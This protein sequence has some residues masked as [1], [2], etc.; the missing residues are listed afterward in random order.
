MPY[1]LTIYMTSTINK[2]Y[3]FS[4]KISQSNGEIGSGFLY[5]P[6]APENYVYVL[7]AKHCI[8]GK[9]IEKVS[10]IPSLTLSYFGKNKLRHIKYEKRTDKVLSTSDK[11]DCA[12]ILIPK[13]R[14]P[15][16]S[17]KKP[18]KTT[19]IKL[20]ELDSGAQCYFRGFPRA[21]QGEGAESELFDDCTLNDLPFKDKQSFKIHI[22]NY[23]SN[24]DHASELLEGC[25]GSGV[26]VQKS[27]QLYL[28]G[29]VQRYLKK[30]PK[31]V[32]RGVNEFNAL[33]KA[34]GFSLIPIYGE[35]IVRPIDIRE[36]LLKLQSTFQ[37]NRISQQHCKLAL[38]IIEDLKSDFQKEKVGLLLHYKGIEVLE[39]LDKLIRTFRKSSLKIDQMQ[40]TLQERILGSIENLLS[41]I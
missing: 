25:S 29:I 14:F 21:R 24:S 11:K 30:L 33:L 12:I 22:K 5:I 34:E 19:G 17:I 8:Y 13:T 32:G 1:L 18:T 38:D 3:D 16:Q 28:L 35:K 31:V 26:L 41:S 9:N 15:K 27:N 40:L 23:D 39:T 6:E 36:K 37:F 7:T 20:S 10:K 2:L 4:V